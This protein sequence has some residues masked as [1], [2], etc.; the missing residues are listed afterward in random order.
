[1]TKTTNQ[2]EAPLSTRV[3]AN[4][5]AREVLS[6]ETIYQN[7]SA[8]TERKQ[9]EKTEQFGA[10]LELFLGLTGKKVATMN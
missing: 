7:Q 3:A 8:R 2:S 10:T 6:G 4:A 1:L 9:K 5:S